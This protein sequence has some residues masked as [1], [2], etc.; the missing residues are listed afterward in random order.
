MFRTKRCG[1]L[2][3]TSFFIHYMSPLRHPYFR[4]EI[5]NYKYGER[6]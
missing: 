3:D 6:S 1:I 5:Q 2:A 4:I